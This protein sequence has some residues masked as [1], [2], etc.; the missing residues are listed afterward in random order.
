MNILTNK[1]KMQTIKSMMPL[2]MRLFT[3][4]ASTAATQY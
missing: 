2:S 1:I 4:E 3:A